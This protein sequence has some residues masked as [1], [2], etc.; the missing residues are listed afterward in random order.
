MITRK[1]RSLTGRKQTTA[2][3]MVESESAQAYCP[4]ADEAR[5]LPRAGSAVKLPPARSKP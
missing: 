4:R 1:Q 5:N 3:A 2:T